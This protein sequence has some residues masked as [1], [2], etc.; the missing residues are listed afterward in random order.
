MQI[1][2]RTSTGEVCI[3]DLEQLNSLLENGGRV[4][5]TV[6]VT[7]NGVNI[8]IYKEEMNIYQIPAP[9]EKEDKK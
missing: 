5:R 4:S 8:N 2:V 7:P 6:D 3:Q 1:W 9:K